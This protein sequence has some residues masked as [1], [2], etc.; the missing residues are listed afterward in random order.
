MAWGISMPYAVGAVGR[1]RSRADGSR[2]VSV[3]GEGTPR[4]ARLSGLLRGRVRRLWQR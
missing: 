1:R 3:A 4:P 2:F